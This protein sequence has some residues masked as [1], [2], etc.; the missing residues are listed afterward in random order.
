MMKIII[1]G[2]T[3]NFNENKR[4]IGNAMVSANNS[5]RLLVD[6]K[7]ENSEYYEK[8][9]EYIFGKDGLCINHLKIEMG[10]DANTSS[11]TEPAVKRFE[12]ENAD[13]RRGAG[14]IL[15]HDAKRINPDL[16]LDML[17]WS[18]PCWVANSEDVYDARYRWYKETLDSAFDEFSLV[19]D[20][21]SVVRNEREADLQ[22]I[23]YFTKRLKSETN[24]RYDYSKIK[25]VAGDEVCTWYIADRMLEDEEL[26][27]AIDVVGTHYTS[28]STESAKRLSD[29]FSKQLWL[30]EGSSPM[31][32]T[33]GTKRFE[34]DKAFNG[35]GGV[36]DIANRFIS[37]YPQGKMTMY[38]YQ[39]VVSSYYDG[40]TYGY[41]QLI[42]A[43]MPWSGKFTL[44][45][46]YYISLHFSRF[47]KKGWAFVES[48]CFADGKIGGDGHAIV[49]AKHSY[50]TLCDENKNDYSIVMT[51]TT[52]ENILC[53]F[54]IKNMK[55]PHAKL[56]VYQSD[57]NG[58]LKKTQ[59]I[60]PDSG[61]RNCGFV[62]KV[63]PNCI[64][65]ISTMNV[66]ENSFEDKEF[67]QNRLD[68]IKNEGLLI[69]PYCDRFDYDVDYLKT[70]GNAPR[71]TSDQGGAFEVEN[72]ALV[73]KIT[74]D[75]KPPEWG[76]TPEPTT[77]LG[78]ERWLDYSVS[79]DVTLTKSDDAANNYAGVGLRYSLAAAG[80]SGYW[81]AVFENGEYKLLA[82]DI[83]VANGK[84]D[85]N[86]SQKIALKIESMQNVV[87]AY[88]NNKFLCEYHD[89][90]MIS[91]GRAALY[92]SYNQNR[93]ENL[94]IEPAINADTYIK[95]V[96]NTDLSFDYIGNWQHETM[97]GFRHYL[98]TV[99]RS[100][101]A[102][103]V[104]EFR[105]K[106]TGALLCGDTENECE[107]DIYLDDKLVGKDCKIPKLSARQSFWHCTGLNNT[108]HV[109]KIKVNS[110]S[111]G[112]DFAQIYLDM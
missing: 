99:S 46:G 37:M 2:N 60:E 10:C 36:L 11:G 95:W 79:A 13:V 94:C 67:R 17:W 107:V 70:H 22:W 1:D 48:A 88:A 69:L 92:S 35:V 55:N 43:N 24:G 89:D 80:K 25:I 81:I 82:N 53:E 111:F 85:I 100:Q 87:K 52:A 72:G 102:G 40:V 71:Y 96:N 42:T 77:S 110:G 30:S 20:Y 76:Y 104:L 108:E 109:V 62:L 49:D 7:Y 31:K 6:Y 98:R 15:A 41:K 9:L 57:V 27:C 75:I 29:E 63:E 61:S 23:K 97:S 21:V 105:F 86:V 28:T 64:I 112:I 26:R 45:S 50:I 12:D 39:P 51:N 33:H 34:N 3:A 103:D 78:D 106:G 65:T 59:I 38:Q 8:I 4:Y 84:A 14:F 83:C 16:T 56:Y 93:F 18:E 32:Y 73:Q 74:K 19:F 91:S 101:N 54:E 66:D 68:N 90:F 44:D 58:Y 5:S 47:I